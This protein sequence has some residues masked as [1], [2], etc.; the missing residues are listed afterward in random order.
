ML[1][2]LSDNSVF[3]LLA[4]TIS[5][6][7]NIKKVNENIK[8]EYISLENNNERLDLLRQLKEVQPELEYI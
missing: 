6:F 3:A 8:F 7:I 2:V 4:L 1:L 5:N